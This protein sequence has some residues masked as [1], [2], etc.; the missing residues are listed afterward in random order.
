[1]VTKKRLKANRIHHILELVS[2]DC[3][4]FILDCGLIYKDADNINMSYHWNEVTCKLCLRKLNQE[5]K[6]GK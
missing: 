5:A 4:N 1:M 2:P 3:G 6:D